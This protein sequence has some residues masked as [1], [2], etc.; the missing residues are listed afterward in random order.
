[1]KIEKQRKTNQK[2]TIKTKER[3]SENLSSLRTRKNKAITRINGA[4]EMFDS[5]AKE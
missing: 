4:R 1:M 5:I 3:L 2:H